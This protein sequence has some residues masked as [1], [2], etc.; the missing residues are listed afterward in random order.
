MPVFGSVAEAGSNTSAAV[1]NVTHLEDLCF[2]GGTDESDGVIVSII[3]LMPTVVCRLILCIQVFPIR[4]SSSI[5]VTIH[6]IIR[7]LHLAKG[8]EK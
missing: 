2:T 1:I 7:F 8:I 3:H 6:D 5:A 4:A